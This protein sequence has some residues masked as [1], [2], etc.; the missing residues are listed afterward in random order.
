MSIPSLPALF[1]L[2]RFGTRA[3]AARG[4]PIA[5]ALAAL[6]IGSA[7]ATGAQKGDIDLDCDVDLADVLL[8]QQ[9]LDGEITLGSQAED[10]ADVAPWDDMASPPAPAPDSN[11]DLGD[12]VV[13][14]RAVIEGWDLPS[15]RPVLTPLVGDPQANTANPISIDLDVPV[16]NGVE[17]T[18]TFSVNGR[19]QP[20]TIDVIGGAGGTG[21]GTLDILAL[22]DGDNEITATST[23]GAATSCPAEPTIV[24]YQNDI[25]RTQGLGGTLAMP[26]VLTPGDPEN[27]DDFKGPYT[28]S[29]DYTVDAFSG[30]NGL[31]ILQPGVELE[32]DTGVQLRLDDG[33]LRIQGE[34]GNEVILTSSEAQ[35][36]RGDWHGIWGRSGATVTIEH[37]IIDYASRPDHPRAAILVRGPTLISDTKIYHFLGIGQAINLRSVSEGSTVTIRNTVID[38]RD[39]PYAPP[40]HAEYEG[41]GIDVGGSGKFRVE[42]STIR[43]TQTAIET[44]PGSDTTIVIGPGNY[45]EYNRFGV[46][47]SSTGGGSSSPRIESNYIRHNQLHGISVG[48]GASVPDANPLVRYNR[49]F[50]HGGDNFGASLGAAPIVDARFNWWGESTFSAISATIQDKSDFPDTLPSYVDFVPFYEDEMLNELDDTKLYL[51]VDD[52]SPLAPDTVYQPLDEGPD[53]IVVADDATWTVPLGASLLM[54][55][56]M[57][58][59]VHGTLLVS[60]ASQ[61]P[62][63]FDTAAPSAC[64]DGVDNDGDGDTDYPQDAD[65]QS[66]DDV[67]EDPPLTDRQ[68]H[69]G[70]DND[71]DGTIDHPDSQPWQQLNPQPPVDPE[72]A[73]L[74]TLREAP[75]WTDHWTGIQIHP[76]STGSVIDY[77]LIDHAIVGLAVDSA[78]DVVVSNSTI[79]RSRDSGVLFENAAGGQID[80]NLI[81]SGN[82]E[83]ERSGTG[84]HVR[85]SAPGITANTIQN[86]E[87]GIHVHGTS[88]PTIDGENTITG[89]QWGL[90]IQGPDLDSLELN[91]RPVINANNIHGNTGPLELPDGVGFPDSDFYR[92]YEVGPAPRCQDTPAN[93][94]LSDFAVADPVTS[95]DA[96]GNWWGTTVLAEIMDGIVSHPDSTVAL[97]I[98][99]YLDGPGGIAVPGSNPAF[100]ALVSNVAVDKRS[101]RPGEGEE[102]QI[103]FS[104]PLAGTGEIRIYEED[105]EDDNGQPLSGPVLVRTIDMPTVSASELNSVDWDGRDDSNNL[106]PDE[107]Y[108]YV[109]EVTAGGVPDTYDPALNDAHFGAGVFPRDANN[110]VLPIPQAYNTFT[111]DNWRWEYKLEPHGLT[112]SLSDDPDEGFPSRVSLQIGPDPSGPPS[113]PTFFPAFRIPLLNDQPRWFI[114]D[115][116]LPNGS[117]LEDEARFYFPVPEPMRRNFV[118]VEGTVPELLG[119]VNGLTVQDAPDVPPSVTVRSNPYLVRHSYEQITTLA[120]TLDTDAKVTVTVFDETGE[121]VASPVYYNEQSAAFEPVVDVLQAGDPENPAV[122]VVEWWGAVGT[123][124]PE[125]NDLDTGVAG[126]H[127]FTIR[128][129]NPD[130]DDLYTVYRGVI[131]VRE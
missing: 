90:W 7:P 62:V 27:D 81:D 22:F 80:A 51:L 12:L 40:A 72:C 71:G 25:D 96:T 10:N 31:L 75:T 48:G 112:Q 111:N 98:A 84:I 121:E 30:K 54:P 77:A 110:D 67:T 103:S 57:G 63:T 61:N 79:L 53:S 69:D 105:L 106:V 24:T 108:A 34:P 107:A 122:H 127:T 14:H 56:G 33:D 88:N 65:C 32:F 83:T 130:Q 23:I 59:E 26:L 41:I 126:V 58:I 55:P 6:A 11:V 125:S 116:R 118:M 114:F 60:G 89:N 38:N 120:Y 97:D 109:I 46:S 66:P 68:C 50:D 104:S 43:G 18:V 4:L 49:I 64:E 129:E 42:T 86:L 5:A 47:V 115:G 29:S 37:A 70:I 8:L 82:T 78:P 44:G 1:E 2:V 94:C 20:D 16:P 28:V 3:L 9:H 119:P 123:S 76:E 45:I 19:V 21:T 131:Q 35:P 92:S 93:V 39:N 73:E 17:A 87:V 85:D 128:A 101:F 99:D 36:S 117:F 91:P 95:I 74:K 124:A 52:E 113:V 15:G 102:V 13:L 100:S